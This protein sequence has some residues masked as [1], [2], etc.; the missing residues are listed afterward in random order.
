MRLIITRHG[1]TEENVKEILMGNLL[2]GKLTDNG[3]DQAK[4]LAKR[5]SKEKIDIIYSSDLARASDTAKEVA[6][7]HQGTPLKLTEEVQE[8]NFGDF[9]GKSIQEVGTKKFLERLKNFDFSPDGGESDKQM[10]IRAERFLGRI[11]KEHPKDNVLVVTHEIFKKVL[12]CFIM[13]KD[14]N[15]LKKMDIMQNTSLSILEVDED[16]NHKIHLINCTEH[17]G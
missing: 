12:I 2:P 5:L 8:C 1:E 16:R 11:I 13:K 17:L 3:K 7:Y 14:S 10:F 9:Q 6:K 4:K 15:Y